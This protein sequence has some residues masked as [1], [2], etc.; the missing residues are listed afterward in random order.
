VDISDNSFGGQTD[1]DRFFGVI[2]AA[3]VERIV[4]RDPSGVN[5][6]TVDHLQYGI[7][8]ATAV[9]EPGTHALLGGL[10]VSGAALLLRRSRATRSKV[11]WLGEV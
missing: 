9:P 4:I 7:A 2:N 3:G 10:L 6:L 8:G 1:E 5:N 11:D